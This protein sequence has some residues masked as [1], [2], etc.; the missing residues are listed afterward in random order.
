MTAWRRAAALLEV[1]GVFLAGP[2]VAGLLIQWFGLRLVNPLQGFTV[3]ITDAELIT[4]ARQILVLLVV[5]YAGYFLLAIP[6]NWWHRRRGPAAYGLTRAGQPWTLLLL[7]GVA[8]AALAAWPVVGLQVVDATYNL[9][10]TVPWRQAI[11][12]TSWLRWEFWLFTAVASWGFSAFVEE[13]FFRGYCQRRLAEDW[14]NGPA[15]LGVACLCTFAHSQYLRPDAYNVGM[16]ASVFILS[17]GLGVVFA[18]TRSLVPSYIA[19]AIINVPMTPRWQVVVVI[20]M[21]IGT[22]VF[23][24]RGASVLKQVF[25]GATVVGCFALAVVGTGWAIAA[26]RVAHLDYVAAGMVVVAVGLYVVDRLRARQSA[27]VD[28]PGS[29]MAQGG[30]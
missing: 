3:A 2:L 18:W 15:I 23:A 7:A 19:H 29:T 13:L 30:F 20:A 25:S 5:Q 28:A 1:F 27:A 10:E 21:A 24:Y 8:T 6:I 11:F 16:I 17:I 22:I 26:Q 9:G 12:D 14:G 4:A